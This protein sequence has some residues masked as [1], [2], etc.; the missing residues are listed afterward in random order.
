MEFAE[1]IEPGT[2]QDH[3]DARSFPDLEEPA[4]IAGRRVVVIAIE[5]LVGVIEDGDEARLVRF[6]RFGAQSFVGL[7]AE[8]LEVVQP[9][10]GPGPE[11]GEDASSLF[12]RGRQGEHLEMREPTPLLER[13][14]L[15]AVHQREAQ[16]VGGVSDGESA[17]ERA[18]QRLA[19]ACWADGDP[20]GAG[21]GQLSFGA[22]P[23]LVHLVG[24]RPADRRGGQFVGRVRPPFRG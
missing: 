16:L 14:V 5:Q 19:T 15:A 24:S 9:S 18:E 12:A 8:P 17:D 11:I 2:A 21:S 10:I 23:Q 6:G 7:V 22:E 3:V 4:Q 13:G 20:V 1:P